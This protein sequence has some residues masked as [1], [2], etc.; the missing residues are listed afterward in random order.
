MQLSTNVQAA[1]PVT[2]FLK[3][4]DAISAKPILS[5]VQDIKELDD[6]HIY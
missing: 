3:T 4:T 6:I 5:D 2:I 1:Q